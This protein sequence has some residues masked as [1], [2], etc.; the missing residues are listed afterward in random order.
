M[1]KMKL[2]LVLLLG[3]VLAWGTPALAAQELIVSAAA[4]LTNAMKVVAAQYEKTH[5]GTKVLC[6]FA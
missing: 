3:V 4:S 2:I 6:N 1:T 5:P